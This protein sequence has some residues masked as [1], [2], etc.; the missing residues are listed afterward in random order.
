LRPGRGR[1]FSGAN[2][3]AKESDREAWE[4]NELSP[5][6]F[7][8]MSTRRRFSQWKAS[9]GRDPGGEI[10]EV[11]YR[12]CA[13]LDVHKKS[14]SV[15]VSCREADGSKRQEIRAFATTT[16]D[17]LALADWLGEQGVTHVAMEAT[18]VYWR[19]VWAILEG[20]HHLLLANPQHM[21]AVPGRKTD[22]KDCEWI[23]DLLQHG[24]LQG[25][26]VPLTEIQDLR[27]LTRYRAELT[28]AQTG[29]ANRIQKLLEQANIKLS[30]VASNTLGVSG[31]QMLRALIAGETDSGQLAE[32][33]R[34]RLRSKIPELRLALEGR[35]RDHH[36]FLLGEYLEEW[37]AIGQR[38]ARLEAEIERRIGPFEYA[39]ALWQTIPGIERVT[40]CSLVAEIG[41]DM[42]QFPSARHLASWAAVCPGNNESGGK[43]K[44]GKTRDGNRW[45][46]RTLCQAAWAVTRKKKCYLSAQFKRIAARRGVKRAVMA[47][48]HTMLVTAY[49]MLKKGRSYQDLGGDYLERINK[50]QLQRYFVKRLQNLGLKVTIQSV[51]ATA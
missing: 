31:R 35:V 36:R 12:C 39:V 38:I 50:D 26:F 1:F 16:R 34:G 21:Q 37:D 29:V 42:R 44:S 33:A 25:S 4:Y 20:H 43:R 49:T 10:M 2:E 40:A 9:S 18:G 11:V 24:L 30:S 41:V 28:Q 48:A 51:T 5:S 14:V 23:A 27:D 13:G 19:P 7:F 45:L 6:G 15:C 8:G 32:R 22:T 17:L 3:P 46:R 47:V